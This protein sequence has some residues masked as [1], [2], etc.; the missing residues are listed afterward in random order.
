MD[1]EGYEDI[2]AYQ[3]KLKKN[4]QRKKQMQVVLIGKK[5]CKYYT[6]FLALRF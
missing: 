5:R 4:M 3:N 1:Q 6:G 2:K